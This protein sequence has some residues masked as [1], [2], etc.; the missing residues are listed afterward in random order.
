MAASNG[1]C[2]AAQLFIDKSC[3]V[4]FEDSSGRTAMHF[5]AAGS[6]STDIL[7]LLLANGAEVNA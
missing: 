6:S 4:N 7:K 3:E 5:A 2:Q 1:D